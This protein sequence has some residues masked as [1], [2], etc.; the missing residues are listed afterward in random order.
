MKMPQDERG[1]VPISG[2]LFK[3]K[4]SERV[5]TPQWTKRFF[6]LE[7]C[8]LKYYHHESSVEAAKVIPLLSVES[9]RRFENGDH[10]VF[11]CVSHILSPLCLFPAAIGGWGGVHRVE[12]SD[13]PSCFLSPRISTANLPIAILSL[14]IANTRH[15]HHHHH[16][17]LPSSFVLKT[18]ERS[19]FLRAES[20]GDMKRWV[21]GLQEQQAL[22]RAKLDKSGGDPAAKSKPKHYSDIP[23]GSLVPQVSGSRLLSS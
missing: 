22:W 1:P 13:V 16:V 15:H 14:A 8:D 4:A 11:R 21:R 17:A 10:G 19:Y 23:R 9:V 3:M 12:S 18:P 20:K 2:Y 6:A 5:L 7:G